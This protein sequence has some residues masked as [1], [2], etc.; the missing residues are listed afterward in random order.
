MH[1][2]VGVKPIEG[3]GEYRVY[4]YSIEEGWNGFIAE[5]LDTLTED[6]CYQISKRV[7][8]IK[9]K[10]DM[11]EEQTELV[12][13]EALKSSIKGIIDYFN[14]CKFSTLYHHLN[15]EIRETKGNECIG[16][17]CHCK[18]ISKGSDDVA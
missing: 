11:D 18:G 17:K 2:L 4:K 6:S 10:Y 9:T 14:S 15:I 7:S 16:E 1:E 3:D 13:L 12:R 8:E 5:Y